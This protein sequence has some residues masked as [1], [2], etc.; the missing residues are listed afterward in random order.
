MSEQ[1]VIATLKHFAGRKPVFRL[2]EVKQSL[3]DERPI[4]E[5]AAAI[6]PLLPDLDLTLHA[7]DG[8]YDLVRLPAPQPLRP[9]DD[10]RQRQEVF[11]RSPAVPDTMQRLL[12]AYIEKKTGKPWDDPVVLDRLRNAIVAQKSR[13]WKEKSVSY[14]KGYHVL[15]YLAYHAPVY[16]VQFEHILWQL[17]E[18]GLLKDRMRVLDVGSGPGMVPLALIDLL[19]RIG[20]GEAHLFAVERSEENI[21][22]YSALVPPAAEA[23]GVRVTVEQPIGADLRSLSM[24]EIPDRIDLM[25]FSN[26]LSELRQ[27]TV[28]ERA[29]LLARLAG[30]L[31]DDGTI[32]VIE[33][34]DLANSTMLR[35]T[36]RAALDR[37]LTVYR[38]C[39][40]IWGTPCSPA[41][42][43]TFEQ[44][45][46]IRPPRLMRRLAEGPEAYRFKNT[47]IK[48]SS[49]VLR[50]DQRTHCDYR[51]PPQAKFARLSQLRRHR[52]RR[53]NV[54]AAVMSGN[55]GGA[56]SEVYKICD[57]TAASPAYAVVPGYLKGES[58]EV[59]QQTPYGGIVQFYGVTVRYNKEHDAYNLVVQPETRIERVSAD[60]GADSC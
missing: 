8:D 30:R 13:Y 50:K 6:E 36:V 54:V 2:S 31:A 41:R 3:A 9:V 17:M 4:P 44:K 52:N 46:D 59:L 11:L 39:S 16:L 57:G 24:D 35:R 22:A 32:V 51:V 55:L 19:G 25:V 48:Y 26:V 12:E 15:G 47:D 27:M 7:R 42:C 14:K 33:P 23:A 1:D 60:S 10:A 29:D 28:D 38:P 53:I 56:G 5:L 21:E 40:F 49:A 37:G 43:W 20:G 18:D 34:A 58:R 45:G